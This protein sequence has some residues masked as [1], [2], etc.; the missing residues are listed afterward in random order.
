MYTLT[1]AERFTLTNMVIAFWSKCLNHFNTKDI[2][3]PVKEL[4]WS[5]IYWCD[6]VSGIWFQGT[7][8][9]TKIILVR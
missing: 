5:S 2:S 9:L 7:I 3:R 4:A 6:S 1:V 8:S